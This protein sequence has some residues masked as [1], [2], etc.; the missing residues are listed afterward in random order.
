MSNTTTDR[1]RNFIKNKLRQ[2]LMPYNGDY[3]IVLESI[4]NG[5]KI[6]ETEKFN[7]NSV[8]VQ[9][10]NQYKLFEPAF[11]NVIILNP[12]GNII[13]SVIS[14]ELG[15]RKKTQ[16]RTQER[17]TSADNFQMETQSPGGNGQDQFTMKEQ[18]QFDRQPIQPI[19]QPSTYNFPSQ[20]NGL[21]GLSGAEIDNRLEKMLKTKEDAKEL[22]E[23]RLEV[24]KLKKK[25]KDSRK[26]HETE[27]EKF[28]GDI[29]TLTKK[30]KNRE[31]L[32]QLG[33]ILGSSGVSKKVVGVINGIAETMEDTEDST[34]RFLEDGNQE[35]APSATSDDDVAIEG[36]ED[37]NNEVATIKA[38]L[39]EHIKNQSSNEELAQL[40][41]ILI[42]DN[43]A[44]GYKML[45]SLL[46]SSEDI[47]KQKLTRYFKETLE[48]FKK[49]LIGS[50]N[51][52]ANINQN[53]NGYEEDIIDN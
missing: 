36:T 9:L 19:S 34:K 31:T 43:K 44:L 21:A 18:P 14:P 4:K 47:D 8:D 22:A 20:N 6:H 29:N 30:L 40:Y 12:D 42:S 10:K 48:F 53:T 33:Q 51:V 5:K 2:K 52:N 27:V 7:I 50:T 28:E 38:S 3:S 1:L 16:Q 46:S 24:P 39:I 17:R 32:M 35:T 45:Y 49:L 11:M 15:V 25:I 37:A 13:D 23:L 41:A 26:D